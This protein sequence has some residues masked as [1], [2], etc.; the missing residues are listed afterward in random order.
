MKNSTIIITGL[1]LGVAG[2]IASMLLIPDKETRRKLK[3]KKKKQEYQDY[4]ENN[5]N[6]FADSVSNS[7][8]SAEDQTEHFT[9]MAID[10]A[11]KLKKEIVEN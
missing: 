8:D 5:Y 7:F 3:I 10:K 11:K 1:L 6:D 2:T 9:K 4:L